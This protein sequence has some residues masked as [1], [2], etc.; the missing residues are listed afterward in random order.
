[1]IVAAT[2]GIAV[3]MVMMVVIVTMVMAVA[4]HHERA[5]Q[6]ALD[7]GSLFTRA[8]GVLDR[9]PH[10]LS[11]D[12]HLVGMA[13]VVTPQPAGAVE[14]EERRR[15]LHLIRREGLGRSLAVGL[16]DA[17]REWPLVLV[18]EHL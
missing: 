7:G 13:V 9:E 3:F 17:D 5:R 4:R 14:H 6:A 18:L 10:Q 8:L 1:M 11:R 16:V 15:S 12:H 2:A